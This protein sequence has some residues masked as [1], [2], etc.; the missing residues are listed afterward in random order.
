MTDDSRSPQNEID[1]L[2]AE[3]ATL[4]RRLADQPARVRALEDR[5]AWLQQQ[6]RE[7]GSR[8]DRLQRT[9]TD[10]RDQLVTL[11]AEV[12]R[13]AQPPN[14]YATV[15]ATH[16]D[17]TVDIIQAGRKLRV[18][19]GPGIEASDLGAGQEVMLN[20]A[21]NVVTACGFER[22]GE[23]VTI[24]ELLDGNRALVLARADEERVVRLARSLADQRLRVGD[25]VTLEPRSGFVYERIPKAEVEE[26]VLEEVPDIDYAD[27]GGLAG[28]IEQIRD[29]V[30]LP[31]L[32]PDLFR[33]HG[34]KAPKGILLYGPP[35]CGKTLIAKA[36]AHS[37]AVQA[38]ERNGISG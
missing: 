22:I 20:E 29:A 10:A 15:V 6:S 25:A 30:E 37:L 23:L 26:L 7:L 3:I 12:E 11:R 27:I 21:L 18:S 36:V 17:G 34:L 5:A 2:Q 13:L 35:G 9:L 8:N 32:H 31:F 4:R 16:D 28:Q 38:A 19:L 33:E 1:L 14:G 24:K